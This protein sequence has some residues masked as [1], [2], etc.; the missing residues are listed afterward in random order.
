MLQLLLKNRVRIYA[1]VRKIVLM[2]SRPKSS[3]LFSFRLFLIDFCSS[4]CLGK[5][6]LS[7][8]SS[9]FGVLIVSSAIAFTKNTRLE[10]TALLIT[11]LY[12]Q[13][14]QV[15][16]AELLGSMMSLSSRIQPKQLVTSLLHF[17]CSLS[18]MFDP[19]KIHPVRLE[20]ILIQNFNHQDGIWA[21]YYKNIILYRSIIVPSGP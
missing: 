3:Q 6:L 7:K 20:E 9:K 17:Q 13:V 14:P 11:F 15:L 16:L 4:I 12:Q 8:S 19:K 10:K 2:C 21:T 1:I 5:E 18:R